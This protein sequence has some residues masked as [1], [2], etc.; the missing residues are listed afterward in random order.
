MSTCYVQGYYKL[1]TVFSLIFYKLLG[2]NLMRR[3]ENILFV[4]VSRNL[5][6]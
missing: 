6:V 4:Y 5:F 3:Y 1:F 2:E